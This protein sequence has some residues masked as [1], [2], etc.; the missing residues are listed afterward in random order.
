MFMIGKTKRLNNVVNPVS[1]VE[2]EEKGPA[3]NQV[4]Q[5]NLN[6]LMNMDKDSIKKQISN[7]SK[8]QPPQLMKVGANCIAMPSRF[9]SSASADFM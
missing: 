3:D 6:D 4:K 2:D 1:V 8:T 5:I 7:A 9:N